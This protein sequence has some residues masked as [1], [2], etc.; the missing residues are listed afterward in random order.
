MEDQ[1]NGFIKINRSML[2][3]E[4]YDDTITVRVFL[5]LLLSANFKATKWHGVELSPGDLITSY[6]S[7]AKKLKVGVRT[8]RTVIN[9]LKATNEI[10]TKATSQY[11]VISIVNWAKFQNT[12]DL[13]THKTTSQ[14]THDRH[15]SDT[16]ATS[17]RQQIKNVKNVKKEKEVLR[18]PL[19]RRKQ[20]NLGL[21]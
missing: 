17:D 18:C 6:N 1:I 15:A 7:L 11:T 8:I 4:W 5:H 13:A 12:N 21:V 10:T 9:K 19:G 3:W 20:K 14:A 2:N 16:Q